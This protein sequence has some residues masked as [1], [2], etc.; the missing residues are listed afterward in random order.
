MDIMD[1]MDVMDAM[2]GMDGMDE[3]TTTGPSLVAAYKDGS[4]QTFEVVPED[5]RLPRSSMEDLIGGDPEYNAEEIRAL[6]NGKTGPHRDIVV[7]N[8]AAALVVAGRA[9]N[10]A[11][12]ASEAADAIDSGKASAKLAKL[13]EIT[14]RKTEVDS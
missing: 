6:L 12:G 10:I 14:N 4:V 3:L 8:T 13:I 1:V 2:D 11:D 7:L 5:A 9:K